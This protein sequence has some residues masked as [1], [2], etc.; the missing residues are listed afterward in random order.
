MSSR[1]RIRSLAFST[2]LA[3]CAVGAVG[4]APGSAGAELAEWDQDRVTGIAQKFSDAVND[5]YRS[6]V[7]RRTGAE[8]GSGQ[9]NA[10]LRLKDKL[11]VARNEARHLA[12]ARARPATRLCPSTADS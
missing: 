3:L 2:L 7:S 10:Y 12:A 4:L 5:V 9:S 1:C 8:M 11:R 6:I